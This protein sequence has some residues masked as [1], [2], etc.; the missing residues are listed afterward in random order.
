M[1]VE[2]NVSR[3]FNFL[4][5]KKGHNGSIRVVRAGEPTTTGKRGRGAA[6]VPA[7]NALH[8]RV[9]I[10]GSGNKGKVKDLKQLSG[11]GSEL[12]FYCQTLIAL[13]GGGSRQR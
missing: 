13:G 3:K 1:Q 5:N 9:V 11:M 8:I 12:L 10:D 6:E 7:E 4:L 2:E